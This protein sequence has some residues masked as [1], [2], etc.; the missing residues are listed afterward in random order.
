RANLETLDAIPSRMATLAEAKTLGGVGAILLV[1]GTFIPFVGIIG[2]ILVLIAV[3][4][5]S[6]VT[7]DRSVFDNMLYGVIIA[8]IGILVVSL[9]ILLPLFGL[10]I[11]PGGE[12]PPLTDPQAFFVF[13][14]I[15]LGLIVGWIL[16][17]ISAVFL[18]R[19]FDSIATHMN[20]PRFRTVGLLY[21][22]GA[23]LIIAIGIGF[24]II[25]IAEI[26]MIVAFFSIQEPQPAP[27]VAEPPAAP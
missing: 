17:I 4:Y 24:I 3:K 6:D 1:L 9:L 22:V 8:I 21:F 12:F 25:F 20:V 7:R 15:A 23:I 18:R 16:A 11:I 10:G 5:I 26:L 14:T 19:S 13:G 2:F 27:A